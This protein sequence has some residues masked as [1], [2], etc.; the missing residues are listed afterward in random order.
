MRVK[1]VSQRGLDFSK[2]NLKITNKY[3]ARYEAVSAVLDEAPKLLDW[4]HRDLVKALKG[5]NQEG[6]RRGR[7]YSY[8]SEHVLR[9]LIC[10]VMEGKS[11]RGIVVRID[12][13]NFLRRFV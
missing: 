4:I 8:T 3:Y 12:D 13:S 11:L 9:I 7:P 2:S 1:H 10:Q 6:R 5:V